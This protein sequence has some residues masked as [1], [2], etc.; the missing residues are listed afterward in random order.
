MSHWDKLRKMTKKQRQAYLQELANPPK[1]EQECY[2]KSFH[3]T[4]PKS[5]KS[6]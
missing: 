2:P 4:T 6:E 1:D 3:Q 5:E